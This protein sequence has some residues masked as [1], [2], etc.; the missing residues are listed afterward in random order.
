LQACYRS[1]SALE[2]IEQC[3]AIGWPFRDYDNKLTRLVTSNVF[4]IGMGWLLYVLL[5]NLFHWPIPTIIG[6]CDVV[7]AGVT[8][9]AMA[10][11]DYPFH[12]ERPGLV[13]LGLVMNALGMA[14]LSFVVLRVIG[15]QVTTFRPFPSSCG[16]VSRP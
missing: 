8:I 9:T 12:H 15:Q 4:V 3:G 16:S 7:A 2:L 11:E 14:F 13:R 1:I 5:H 6:A 10:F